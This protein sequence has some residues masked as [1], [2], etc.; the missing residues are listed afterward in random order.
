MRSLNFLLLWAV[1]VGGHL[2]VSQQLSSERQVLVQQKEELHPLPAAALKILALEYRDLAADLVFSRTQ[3]FYGGKLNRLEKIDDRSWQVIYRRLD[4]VS[5]LDPYF[6]DPYFFGQAVLTW[7]ARMPKEANALLDRGRKSRTDDW[8]LPF[9]MGFNSFYFLQDFGQAADYLMESSR[10]PGSPP[11]VALLA[12]RLASQSGGTETAIAFLQQVERHTEDQAIRGQIQQRLEALKGI[13]VLEQAVGAYRRQSGRW[14]KD[15]QALV[16]QGLLKR[17]P[18]D[19]YGGT[20][21]LDEEGK[22]WTTSHL[23]PVEE[24]AG[25]RE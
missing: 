15:L 16:E 23:R 18:S 19:P 24:K 6:I 25:K 2:F 4:A 12:A 20:F 9:F 17:L 22:V 8:I 7:E 13:W 5:Q 10:R 14:P 11:L 1:L 3:T 21:Y